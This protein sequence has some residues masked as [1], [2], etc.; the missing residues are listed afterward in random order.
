MKMFR[1]VKYAGHGENHVV[2]EFDDYKLAIEFAESQK[3]SKVYW[4]EGKINGEWYG[5]A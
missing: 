3:H 1:V 2:K 5:L 4:I